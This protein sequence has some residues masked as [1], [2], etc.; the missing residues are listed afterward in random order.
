MKGTGFYACS[1]NAG[2]SRGDERTDR[3]RIYAVVGRC[4]INRGGE[5]KAE[6]KVEL[7]PFNE[8]LQYASG[9]RFKGGLMTSMKISTESMAALLGGGISFSTPEKDAMGDRVANGHHFNLNSDPD[10][11]WLNWSPTLEV[12]ELPE[13]FIQKTKNVQKK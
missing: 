4:I 5:L 8:P 1:R 12:G 2:T 9:L 3:I 6:L 7:A 11:E 13:A 10:D